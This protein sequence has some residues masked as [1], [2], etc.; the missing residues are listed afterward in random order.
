M[1]TVVR[2]GFLSF[3]F[4]FFFLAS[5][6]AQKPTWLDEDRERWLDKHATVERKLMVPMRDGVRLATDLYRPK[7]YNRRLPTLFWRTPYNF[8]KLSG[9]RLKFVHEAIAHGYAFLIQN[10]R[11]KFFSE[12]EWKILGLPRTDGYDALD[13]ISKQSWSNGKVGTIGCSSSAEWQ[14]ALAAMNH[15]AHAAMVPMAPGAGIGQVGEFWE[16]GN[17]YRGGV[18]QMFY[19]TWLYGVQNVQR[20][21]LPLGIERGDVVRL[22]KYF[23][24]APKMPK[25]EWKEKLATL[26]LNAAMEAV[27]GPQGIFSEFLKRKPNDPQWDRGGLWHGRDGCGV[28]GLWLF[29]WYDISTAPN[30][31][32]VDH[33]RRTATDA[34]V[35]ANQFVIM[36]PL[37]HCAFF[38]SS[39]PL[40]L[41]ERTVNNIEFPYEEQIFGWFDRWLKNADNGF[42][43]NTPKV[44][45]FTFGSDQWRT[46]TTWPP[47]GSKKSSMYLSSQDRANSLFGDGALLAD[48]PDRASADRFTYDPTVPVP[49]LGGGIC[50]I[51]GAIEAGAF[52]QRTIEARADV[53]VYTSKKLTEDFEVT[54][55]VEV[56]LYVSSDAKDTDFTVKLIDVFPDGTAYNLDETIQ[57]VRYREGY[58]QTVFMEQGQVYKVKMPSMVTSN[59]F[60][61]GHRIRLDVSSS[62]FPR[63]ARNLNTGGPNY[64][65]SKPSIAHNVVHHSKLHPSRVIFTVPGNE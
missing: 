1:R 29:S 43:K 52:D 21:L 4:S 2:I 62:N 45:Y 47:A 41:G 12:G 59:V 38:R 13:W 61:K 27:D 48:P 5:S 37:P 64:N 42:L 60:K 53:L 31:A 51:G 15:P 10:E 24:L 19:L 65:E 55:A 58:D 3:V 11:G 34:E 44:Q 9:T 28:P 18:E 6:W 20:P 57:R 36:A 17:W 50:C 56:V 49:S 54:G 30:L 46:A 32:M 26:P 33:I 23:D 7:D 39:S 63:F 8:N 16:Q 35:R 40:T 14:M 22:S 25:I